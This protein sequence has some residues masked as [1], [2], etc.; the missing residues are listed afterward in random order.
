MIKVSIQETI[1]SGI[2]K[3]MQ[4]DN[5]PWIPPQGPFYLLDSNIVPYTPNPTILRI[6]TDKVG[7]AISIEIDQLGDFGSGVDVR[8]RQKAYTVVASSSVITT[9]IQLGQGRNLITVYLLNRPTDIAYLIVNATTITALWEAFARVLYSVST[10]IIDEQNRAISSELA[11]RL[12]EPYISF[13][14]L[15]PDI[16]SIKV[17]AIRLASKGL[18]HSVGT[19]LGVTELIKALSLST[20]VYSRMDK[21]SFEIFPA[22]DP[23]TKSASQF[24]GLEAHIWLPN[25]EIASWLAFLSFISNQP[26]LYEIQSITES[27]VVIK[28]QGDIQKHLFD[29]DRF[30]TSFLTAQASSE[31]FKSVF[32]NVTMVSSQIL[33]MCVGTYT[34][35]L[36]ITD[37]NLLGNC[38]PHL[39]NDSVF[40]SGC[41]FD[42]DAIDP[43]TDG[44]IDLSLSGRF[45]SDPSHNLDT[46]IIPSSAYIGNICSF[47]GWYTQMVKNHKYEVEVPVAITVTGYVQEGL[48]WVLQSPNGNK[49]LVYV[50]HLTETLIAKLMTIP[51][52]GDLVDL[53][54]TNV[55]YT[56]S[57][58]G[59]ANVNVLTNI[60]ET[61]TLTAL[62]SEQFR[63]VG[64]ISGNVGVATVGIPLLNAYIKV[65]IFEG[66]IPFSTG[67]EFIV[68]YIAA[69]VITNIPSTSDL[70]VGMHITGLNIPTNTVITSV[71][72]ANQITINQDAT[73]SSLATPLVADIAI[74]NSDFKVIKPDL[75]E[76]AF[77]ITDEGVLQVVTPIGSELLV[78]TLYI[79]SDDETSV[80][81]VTVNNEN[82]LIIDKIFPV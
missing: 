51:F 14:G 43:F 33:K 30:G 19:N 48:A 60:I 82:V 53:T 74:D 44:W 29:F 35:D 34:F 46:F 22:L 24:G 62:N 6:E 65:V 66:T 15:L 38:R 3:S 2:I 25:I 81:W 28:Y 21:D 39:D 37:K 56:G 47:D 36:Y 77:A 73:G 12:I 50:N 63:I 40:D 4:I 80:W 42:T 61:F 11:T 1:Y 75:S 79:V 70:Q 67:D 41:V 31:C 54:T 27:E 13:Q 23:W 16:Q 52:I 57:G 8:K 64:S 5:A 58:D 49:W 20:P 45:D 69:N 71:D 78:N 7:E 10:R 59:T 9:G 32:I 72:S 68:N 17:L 26:D 18:L 55:L 76:A